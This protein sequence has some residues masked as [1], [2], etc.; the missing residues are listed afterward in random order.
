MFCL[1]VQGF[2]S[3]HGSFDSPR[4]PP[5]SLFSIYSLDFFWDTSTWW[6]DLVQDYTCFDDMRLWW[7]AVT[8]WGRKV[9]CGQ[10]TKL[11]EEKTAHLFRFWWIY[12]CKYKIGTSSKLNWN[13]PESTVGKQTRCRRVESRSRSLRVNFL[14]KNYFCGR[15]PLKPSYYIKLFCFVKR[16]H[17]E[18][19]ELWI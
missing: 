8:R 16:C 1:G 14:E 2:R 13:S 19:F 12:L 3:E 15:R 18:T 9:G 6:V 17:E 7:M 5:R 4:K 11:P 10:K